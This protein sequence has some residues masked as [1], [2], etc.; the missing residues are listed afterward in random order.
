[1]KKFISVFISVI[2]MLS[3]CLTLCS[4][5]Q[6]ASPIED[7]EYEF[8][9]GTVTITGYTGTDLEIV[10]PDKIEKRPVTT[11][12]N[13]AFIG[14]DMNCVYIPSSVTTIEGRAFYNCTLLNEVTFNEGITHIH[15]NAFGNCEKLDLVTLPDS[16]RYVSE[17]AF[18]G[19]KWYDNQPDGVVYSG[20]AVLF[21]KGDP[22]EHSTNK[23]HTIEVYINES[24]KIIADNA[25]NDSTIRYIHIP[26]SVT[27]IGENSIYKEEYRELVTL[28]GKSGSIV[29][30][31]AFENYA[32]FIAE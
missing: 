30:T 12:G 4:C 20:N 8:I 28:Y 19:S 26:E 29:E 21:Y 31:Y 13:E 10:I 9:D 11:I 22:S 5:G 15:D 18:W 27:Y 7:F 3:V 32:K 2:L 1:M 14:Y 24:T 17:N 23:E 6:S 16:I 25:L